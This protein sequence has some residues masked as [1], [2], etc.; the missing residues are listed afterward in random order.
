M[1]FSS[2]FAQD[3]SS[4]A[5]DQPSFIASMVPLA[6]I[7]GIFYVLVLRPQQKRAKEHQAMITAVKKG[8][9]VLTGGGIV[10]KVVKVDTAAGTLQVEITEGVTVEVTSGSITLVYVKDAVAPGNVKAARKS[11]TPEKPVAND[12]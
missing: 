3:A 10:G 9:K 2:A 5:A 6:L 1:F 8:D 12:N 4:I 7:M 11:K